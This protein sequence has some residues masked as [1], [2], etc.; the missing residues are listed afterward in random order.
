MNDRSSNPASIEHELAET[1]ARLGNHLEELTR[2]LSP[3]QLLDEALSYLRNGQGAAFARN[4]GTELRDNPLPVAVTGIGLAWLMIAGSTSWGRS[5]SRAVVP[6][7]PAQAA[8]SDVSSDLAERARRAGEAVTRMA[9]E[10]EEAFRARVADARARIMGVQRDIEET[11]AAFG[12]RV[13]QAMDTAQQTARDAGEAVAQAA[14]RSREFVSRASSGIA[15][16]V[17]EN[18]LLLGALGLSAGV[19][20]GALLPRTSQEEALLKPAADELVARG[21]RA[22]EAA[23]SAG[24]QAARE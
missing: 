10:T 9:D 13:Q 2:R 21:R 20:L 18:P 23:A 7:D 17:S 19:L 22:A 15:D 14:Q 4:L 8:R 12:E 11:A 6:Y 5:A 1:R 16:S 24:Y 3:G